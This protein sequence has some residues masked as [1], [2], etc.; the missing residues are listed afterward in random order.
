MTPASIVKVTPL[1][2]VIGPVRLY[3]L[4]DFVHVVLELTIPVTSEASAVPKRAVL[5][6]VN[7]LRIMAVKNAI[8]S[9]LRIVP[10]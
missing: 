7:P 4:L 2:M 9:G 3:G 6:T 10:H 8:T 5:T 1:L